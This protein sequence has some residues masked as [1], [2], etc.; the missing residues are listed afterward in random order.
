MLQMEITHAGD[1]EHVVAYKK[2]HSYWLRV[3][4]ISEMPQNKH[5]GIMENEH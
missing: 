3:G 1:V 4:S 2:I 5:I